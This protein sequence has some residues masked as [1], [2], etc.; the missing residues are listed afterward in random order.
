M[1]GF[2]KALDMSK[3]N[4]KSLFI[5]ITVAIVAVAVIAA[6]FVIPFRFGI[7][8]SVSTYS[9]VVPWYMIREEYNCFMEPSSPPLIGEWDLPERSVKRELII[10][11]KEYS[12]DIYLE[13]K[14]G[15]VK[16]L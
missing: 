2:R 7:S 15:R 5:K 3:K 8:E 12:S 4:G 16:K 13:Y 6:L 9:P 10:F 14:D 1:I 11:G